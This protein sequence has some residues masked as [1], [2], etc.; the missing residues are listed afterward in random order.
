MIL[1]SLTTR[2]NDRDGEFWKQITEDRIIEAN[3]LNDR[4][5]LV[6]KIEVLSTKRKYETSRR[7]LRALRSFSPGLYEIHFT[8]T[9]EFASSKS[10][11]VP[12]S[13]VAA[14]FISVED[15]EEYMKS[16][17]ADSRSIFSS[18]ESM[19]MDVNGV[20]ITEEMKVNPERLAEQDNNLIYIVACSVSGVLIL[21]LMGGLCYRKRRRNLGKRSQRHKRGDLSVQT[22]PA[23]TER[24]SPSQDKSFASLSSRQCFD[25]MGPGE[26]EMDDVSTL[27]EPP[28]GFETVSPK[29]DETVDETFIPSVQELY[30]YGGGRPRFNTGGTTV[31]GG[32]SGLNSGCAG[33][34]RVVFGDDATLEDVYQ[35]VTSSVHQ[36]FQQVVVVVPA[37]KL[38]IVIDNPDGC[39]PVVH[40]VKDTSPLFGNV[41][42]G[43][44]ITHIDEVDCKGLTPTQVSRTIGRRSRNIRTLTVLRSLHALDGS[45]NASRYNE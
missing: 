4:G 20:R 29:A 21:A 23:P 6:V 34:G 3:G 39:L 22:Q 10:D 9:L 38:G 40:A 16:L 11:R 7:L 1:N 41:Y 31:T 2:W 13:V 27:G 17:R 35:N 32:A 42:V 43:D 37:G 30:V 19:S 15:Q 36:S 12:E 28:V 5:G 24:L 33:L 44:L 8:A 25:V 26:N 45:S 14:G 18:L